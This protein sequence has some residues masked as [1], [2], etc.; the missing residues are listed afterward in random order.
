MKISTL[1]RITGIQNTYVLH[2]DPGKVRATNCVSPF[3]NNT[4]FQIQL[5]FCKMEIYLSHNESGGIFFLIEQVN[6]IIDVVQTL[7]LDLQGNLS[8]ATWKYHRIKI[9]TDTEEYKIRILQN[10]NLISSTSKTIPVKCQLGI[11]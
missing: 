10:V 7:F 6:D 4:L 9:D 2:R 11:I 5:K 3:S 1:D 8:V